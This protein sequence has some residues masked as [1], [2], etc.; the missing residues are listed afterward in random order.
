MIDRL[1][2]IARRYHEI[3][4]EMARPEVATDHE[5]LTRLAR[6][7]RSLREI[8]QAYDAF[9]RAQKE[10]E[11]A[12]EMLRHERDADMQEYMRSE[13]RRAAEQVV[14]L[15]EKLK[16]LLLPKDPNDDRDVV[17]EIQGAEG[18][19]EAALFAADLFRMYTR[20]AEKK[21][22][23]VEVVDASP[24][25]IGGYDKITF[26][27]HGQGAYSQLKYE[28]GVHRVQ[29]V[30]KTEAQGRIHT[31]AATVSVLPEADPVEVE[32]KPEDL[33]IKASTSTGPGGQS[34]NTTYSA[35]RITHKPTGIAVSIQDEKSQLQNKE[36]AMRVLRAR[37]Y[38]MKLAEQQESIRAQ[39][40]GMVR[41]GNR[42]EKIRTYNFK[43][44]RVTDHRINLT[45]HKLDRVMAGDL[46]DLVNALIGAER[47]AQLNGGN[48]AQAS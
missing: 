40:R 31:S 44:N 48:E 18:G 37:L 33:E 1:E 43:D 11:S 29:R 24:T 45:L 25:G 34:V 10:M 7:Q 3:E 35:I 20:W 32:L 38:D 27:V 36:K 26:E 19:D 6:E 13:E 23:K 8:V 28:G 16:V 12:R 46:D 22:W 21:G 30:P 17:V 4:N 5:K 15:E 2:A 39:Q 47:T 9:R 42:S 41:T 14:Q